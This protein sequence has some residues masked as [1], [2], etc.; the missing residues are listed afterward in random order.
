MKYFYQ[1]HRSLARKLEACPSGG[2]NPTGAVP[3]LQ[4]LW[5]G[6]DYIMQE[7][8]KRV[9]TFGSGSR[10]GNLGTLKKE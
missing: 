6:K 5:L 9:R 2:K 8:V 4:L 1:T 7:I 3:E 10:A